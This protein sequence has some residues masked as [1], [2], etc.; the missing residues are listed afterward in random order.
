MIPETIPQDPTDED[1]VC[2]LAVKWKLD[3]ELAYRLALMQS[4]LPGVPLQIISG[5]R[6]QEEQDSLRQQGRPAAPDHLSTHRSCPAT[7]ADLRFRDLSPGN[8]EKALF[9]YAARRAGLRVG[10]GSPVD[11]Q[12]GLSSDWNHV[13]LGPRVP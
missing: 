4:E 2:R 13:D 9:A 11:P 6:S 12:T 7:G 8:A 1:G 3:A 10:G 5:Y